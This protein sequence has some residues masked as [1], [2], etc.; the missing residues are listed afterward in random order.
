MVLDLQLLAKVFEHV[1]VELLSIIR[2]KDPGNSESAN[3]ALPNE[4]TNI[5]LCDGC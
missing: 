3:D 4:A 1:V 2:D 5:F